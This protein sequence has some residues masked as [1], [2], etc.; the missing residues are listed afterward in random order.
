M[1]LKKTGYDYGILQMTGTT[2]ADANKKLTGY[3]G[4]TTTGDTPTKFII[5][6]LSVHDLIY[7]LIIAKTC[8]DKTNPG[9]GESVT[10]PYMVTESGTPS[11]KTIYMTSQRDLTSIANEEAANKQEGD[12]YQLGTTLS[13]GDA[14]HT[15]S[16]D[17]GTVSI[18]DVLEVPSVFYRPN[19]TFEFYIEGVYNSAGT[20][21]EDGLNAKFKGLKRDVLMSDPEPHR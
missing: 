7:H 5:F 6:G 18:G 20:L 21:A 2:G 16:Y 8:P 10:I 1:L 11:S 14:Y 9:S 15:Y 3:G 13:W 4:S 12:K 17:A 19:C